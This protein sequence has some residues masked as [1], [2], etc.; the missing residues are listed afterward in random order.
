M[1]NLILLCIIELS[2]VQLPVSRSRPIAV[3]LSRGVY[4]NRSFVSPYLPSVNAN[5]TEPRMSRAAPPISALVSHTLDD[6]VR[7]QAREV[8]RNGIRR[9]LLGN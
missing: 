6:D 4:I 3:G 1:K 5:A 7:N 9:R 8:V 2:D